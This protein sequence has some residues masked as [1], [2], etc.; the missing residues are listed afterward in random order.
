MKK[1]IIGFDILRIIGV[2]SIFCGHFTIEY[3]YSAYG[4]DELIFSLNDLF[5]AIARPSCILLFMISGYA[6]MYNGEDKLSAKAYYM[7]RFKSL[8][9]PF[10]VVYLFAFLMVFLVYD[11]TVGHPELGEMVP[12]HRA[13]YTVLGIDGFM[14]NFAPNFYLIG[15]WF[16]SCIVI[17][18][19]IFPILKLISKGF[20]YIVYTIL[21]AGYFLL[22]FQN[23]FDISPMTNP[24]LMLVY[25]YTGIIAYKLLQEERLGKL[26]RTS[27][28]IVSV[29]LAVPLL[30]NIDLSERVLEVLYYAWSI[31][32]FLFFKDVSMNT[33]GKIF[34]ALKYGAGIS[35]YVILVHHVIILVLFTHH[36]VCDYSKREL[37]AMFLVCFFVTWLAAYWAKKLS[38][39]LT[40]IL[41]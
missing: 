40:K 36:P 8:Y 35:W 23:P 7:R 1:R 41:F 10:Y 30:G 18:Y 24:L 19:G 39:K 15:E 4:H 17:C 27:S 28:A 6:L 14:N 31:A 20:V 11:R 33:E 37:L 3:I 32:L 34:S 22:L 13:V 26:I 12:I 21:L 38:N 16:M 2:F 29:I 9:I 5:N 25:F